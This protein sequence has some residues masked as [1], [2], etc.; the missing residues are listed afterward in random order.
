MHIE[1]LSS[2]MHDHQNVHTLIDINIKLEQFFLNLN[3]PNLILSSKA[4]LK[5][6]KWYGKTKSFFMQAG[7]NIVIKRFP[8]Y[9][10]TES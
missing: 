10:S 7:T 1:L 6:S 5:P 3:Y 8:E 9:K 2:F 4:H